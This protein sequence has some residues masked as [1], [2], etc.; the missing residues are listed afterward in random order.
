MEKLIRKFWED[1][2]QAVTTQN[3]DKILQ[4]FAPDATY[5]FRPAEGMTDS[6]PLPDMAASCLG[7][8]SVLV[9]KYSIERIEELANGSWMS[10]ITA[11]VGKPYF[12]ASFFKFKG[13]K[14]IEL[15]EYYGDF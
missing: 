5:K 8:K 15:I 3:A 10:I 6:I 9:G 11:N 7:Y 2:F 13:D 4:N 1:M 14:I 12:T